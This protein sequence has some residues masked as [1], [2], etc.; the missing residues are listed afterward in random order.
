MSYEQLMNCDSVLRYVDVPYLLKFV[1][2]HIKALETISICPQGFHG[3]NKNHPNP[4]AF[5][6]LL[7]AL[8][9]SNL[10]PYGEACCKAT[11]KEEKEDSSE[12]QW[13]GSGV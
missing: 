2:V 3:L 1:D 13:E 9:L 8:F 11:G 6:P 10:K 5:L 4:K 12:R 7:K